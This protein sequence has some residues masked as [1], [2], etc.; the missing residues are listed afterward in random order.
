[1][2]S[3][4]SYTV[5][6]LDHPMEEWYMNTVTWVQP[7]DTYFIDIRFDYIIDQGTVV[8]IDDVSV[9]PAA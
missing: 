8:A 2:G 3:M 4:P 9:A 7:A 6:A 1:M 5:D